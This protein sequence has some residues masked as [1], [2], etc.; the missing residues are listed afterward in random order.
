[1]INNQAKLNP[2]FHQKTVLANGFNASVGS[3]PTLIPQVEL[4]I[5]YHKRVRMS[6]EINLRGPDGIRTRTFYLRGR[7]S[8]INLP[9]QVT[10]ADVLS[11]SDNIKVKLC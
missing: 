1:M 11:Q 5:I 8:A 7:W 9:A 3:K 10:E 4:S 2:N 6:S